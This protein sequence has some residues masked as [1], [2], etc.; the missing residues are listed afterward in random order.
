MKGG[1]QEGMNE[2]KKEMV[3]R[4]QEGMKTRKVGRK[5]GRKAAR[6]E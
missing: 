4:R 2:D 1:R 6:K 5:R 3:E